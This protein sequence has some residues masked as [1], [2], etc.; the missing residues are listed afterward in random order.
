MKIVEVP[1]EVEE[2]FAPFREVMSRPQFRHFI[3]LVLGLILPCAKKKTVQAIAE[4]YA[5]GRD[6]SCLSRFLEH[7]P[8]ELEKAMNRALGILYHQLPKHSGRLSYLILDDSANEKTGRKIEGAGWFHDPMKLK[9]HIF[10]H[11]YVMALAQVSGSCFPVG[12]R[13]YLKQQFC[14]EHGMVFKTKNE[15][16]AE[17][18]ESYQ[19]RL[20][21]LVVVV[22][23]GWYLNETVVGAVKRRGWR[24]V[25][26]LKLNR[27]VK[28]GAVFWLVRDFIETLGQAELQETNFVPRSHELAI[29]GCL[30]RGW[31]RKIGEV[32]LVFGCNQNGEWQSFA[33][34]L[35]H[36]SLESLMRVYDRRWEI[37]CCFRESKEHLGLGESQA[38]LLRCAV[39][40]LHMVMI[41]W[42]LLA[43]LKLKHGL[44]NATVGDLCRWVG[45]QVERDQIAFIQKH[46]RRRKD[47]KKVERLLLAA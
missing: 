38:R 39:I 25:S 43:A 17:L 26:R 41:A 6:R 16:A 23:D 29:I 4:S 3:R 8:W 15:L 7:S 35:L 21:G 33:S 19:P 22:Y 28:I 20:S 9:R 13:L 32:A 44:E 5:G 47:R 30:R 27:R 34:D 11:N 14:L 42:I 1:A 45:R 40:H 24:W 37:E 31:L 36:W 12:V 2:A 18:I 46:G 10:G